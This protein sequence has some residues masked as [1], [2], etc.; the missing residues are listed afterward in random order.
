MKVNVCPIKIWDM[1]NLIAKNILYRLISFSY[2]FLLWFIGKKNRPK[3]RRVKAV[4]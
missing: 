2:K 4:F 1:K 3:L